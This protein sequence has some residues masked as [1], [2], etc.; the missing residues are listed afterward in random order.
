MGRAR[1]K[2]RAPF[3]R[4]PARPVSLMAVLADVVRWLGL[5]DNICHERFDV[6]QS[7]HD[8]QCPK[9]HGDHP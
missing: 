1:P 3:P 2:G 8:V 6:T 4:N 5:R 9:A 7:I